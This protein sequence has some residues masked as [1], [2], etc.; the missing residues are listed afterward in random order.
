MSFEVSA[1][2]P[3]KQKDSY[4]IEKKKSEISNDDSPKYLVEGY[5][6]FDSINGNTYHTII[7]TDLKTGEEVYRSKEM[8]YGYG[9][10]YRQTAYKELV[11]KGLAKKEDE[12]NWDLNH[13]R[14]IFRVTDV[15]RKKDL[16]K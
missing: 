14:F 15:H 8:S 12:Y 6:W 10:G 7:I 3:I 9:D 4:E 1:P 5:R 2:K 16:P 11:Q 13:K